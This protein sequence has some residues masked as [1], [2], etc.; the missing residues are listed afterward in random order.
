M[1]SV[2]SV[3][4]A[5]VPVLHGA[6]RGER[7]GHVRTTTATSNAAGGRDEPVS[8]ADNYSDADQTNAGSER[9][10]LSTTKTCQDGQVSLV[11][12]T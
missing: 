11:D 3:L 9:V 1:V 10:Q 7:S 6:T 12:M 8:V 4:S 2:T 5:S